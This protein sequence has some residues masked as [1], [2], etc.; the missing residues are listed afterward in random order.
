MQSAVGLDRLRDKVLHL[1]R[2]A[3][4]RLHK[5]GFASLALDQVRGLDARRIDITD[6]DLRAV[7]RKAKRCSTTNPGAAACNERNLAV[8]FNSFLLDA[9]RLIGQDSA[10][11]APR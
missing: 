10:H 8:K 1:L 6:Y 5:D 11:R 2:F 7:V 3:N 4:V 9:I